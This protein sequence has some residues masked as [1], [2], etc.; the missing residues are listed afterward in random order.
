[1]AKLYFRYAAMN[2]GKSLD[3]LKVAYNYRERNQKVIL[4]TSVIDNRYGIGK[5]KSR[6]GVEE[7]AIIIDEKMN[8]FNIVKHLDVNC[9]LVDEI[10][11]FTE[12]HIIQL[13][14]IVDELNIPVICYGLRADFKTNLFK[15]INKLFA[16]ADEVE[17]LK[18]ICDCG[19]KAII[20][21][22]FLNGKIQT[23]GEQI[24]IGNLEY[25]SICRKCYKNYLKEIK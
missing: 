19:K 22:R 8:I 20:N 10:Q 23:E 21:A 3:L 16:I 12:E 14:D 6:V 15:S 18:T 13:S 25:K 11:F 4:L 2:S 24:L 9:V 7:D 5:I 17:E 1:M